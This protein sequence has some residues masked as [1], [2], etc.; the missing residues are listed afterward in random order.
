MNDF[1]ISK[2]G[3]SLGLT[4]DILFL[5]GLAAFFILIVTMTVRT[6]QLK[7]PRLH[8]RTSVNITLWVGAFLAGCLAMIAL[9]EFYAILTIENYL[10]EDTDRHTALRNVSL[11]LAAVFSAP[12]LVWRTVIASKQA[13]TAEQGL[14]TDRI[15]KAVEQIGADKV[16]KRH[17]RDYSGS[18]TY[19]TKARRETRQDLSIGM[20]PLASHSFFDRPSDIPEPDRSKPV[21]TEETT[22][23]LEVRIGGLLALERI[24]RDSLDDHI[25]VMEIICAYVRENA[26]V[27]NLSPRT[28]PFNTKR[29]RADRVMP[30]SW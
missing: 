26:R 8:E 9:Y 11:F 1:D 21:Y 5:V 25:T 2:N 27:R 17:V 20:P 18:P 13:H 6:H 7:P 4:W 22:P 14:Y 29:P 10:D 28:P 23:N 24:A 19:E 30:E 16:V 12:F 3:I 15:A